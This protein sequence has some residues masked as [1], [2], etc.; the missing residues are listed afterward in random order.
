[1]KTWNVYLIDDG[2]EENHETFTVALKN[3]KNAV[4][5]QRTSASVEI[6]D[7]RGGKHFLF[8][9]SYT[10]KNLKA[11]RALTVVCQ[12]GVTRTNWWRRTRSSSP[13]L[14]P[15]RRRRRTPSPTSRRSC[16]GRTSLTLPEEMSR[17][18]G[19]TW[20]TERGNHRTRPPPATTTSTTTAGSC[21]GQELGALDTES[22]ED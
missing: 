17:T 3:P 13:L 20:T 4:L 11:N 8:C 16:C 14:L 1:M 15:S 2:L 21:R 7:P 22:E 12:G 6:I 9:G 10:G 5:G 19:P 18:A